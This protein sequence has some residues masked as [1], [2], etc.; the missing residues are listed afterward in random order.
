MEAK[1]TK[2]GR[3]LLCKA[4]AGI[5]TLSPVTYIALGSGGCS[6]GTPIDVTGNE[7]SLKAELIRKETGAGTYAEELDAESGTYV[8]KARYMVSLGKE[9]LS[10]S[11]ISEAGLIDAEGNLVAYIT[12]YEKGKDSGMEFTFY[13]DEIF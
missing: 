3:E 4:H 1:M 8:V 2:K 11:K 12:F 5:V 13:V 10:D 7:M 6:D 9:E